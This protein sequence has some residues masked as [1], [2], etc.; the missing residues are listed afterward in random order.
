M[1]LKQ[2]EIRPYQ[3]KSKKWRW[4]LVGR[5]SKIVATSHESFSSKRKCIESACRMLDWVQDSLVV[6]V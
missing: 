5:N 1:P 3:D 2:P 4:R 6:D